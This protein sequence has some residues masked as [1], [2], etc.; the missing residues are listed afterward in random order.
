MKEIWKAID[1]KTITSAGGIV[2]AMPA[3]WV[4]YQVFSDS[5]SDLTSE[6]SAHDTTKRLMDSETNEVLRGV[7]NALEGNTKVLEAVLRTYPQP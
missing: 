2:V 6:V 5:F 7:T 3:I 4:M 1:S